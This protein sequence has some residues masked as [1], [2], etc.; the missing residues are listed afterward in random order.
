M[1]RTEEDLMSGS[2][3]QSS[4]TTANLPRSDN[5]NLHTIVP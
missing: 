2:N 5:S 1:T 4:Q 3:P